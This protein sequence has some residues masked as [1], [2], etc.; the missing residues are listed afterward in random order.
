MTKSAVSQNPRI[1]KGLDLSEKVHEVC[2]QYVL[3][4]S[5]YSPE[6]SIAYNQVINTKNMAGEFKDMQSLAII[7]Y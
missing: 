6:V 1:G 7:W 2:I 3:K 5:M 4:L